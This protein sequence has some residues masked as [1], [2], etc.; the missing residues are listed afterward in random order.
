MANFQVVLYNCFFSTFSSD[1]CAEYLEGVTAWQILSLTID[2]MKKCKSL[3][4]GFFKKN[5]PIY[6]SNT[7]LTNLLTLIFSTNQE[8]LEISKCSF[9][10]KFSSTFTDFSHQARMLSSS[11]STTAVSQVQFSKLERMKTWQEPKLEKKFCLRKEIHAISKKS[12][13]H[14]EPENSHSWESHYFQYLCWWRR[15]EHTLCIISHY[16]LL[17]FQQIIH[18]KPLFS[19]VVSVNCPGYMNVNKSLWAPR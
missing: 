15:K 9:S 2:D 1:F 14:E 10:S 13:E 4:Q 18:S 7:F 3:N 6:I 12:Y 8:D 11:P 19:G 17:F 16:Y 5:H